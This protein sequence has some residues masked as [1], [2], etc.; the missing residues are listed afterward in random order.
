MK[1]KIIT[2]SGYS[3]CPYLK[4]WNDNGKIVAGSCSHHSWNREMGE[5]NFKIETIQVPYFGNGAMVNNPVGMPEWCPL[6]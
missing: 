1:F 6:D 3:N 5:P 2:V 4:V